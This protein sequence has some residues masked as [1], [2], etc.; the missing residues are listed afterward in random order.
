MFSD[1][2]VLLS[3]LLLYHPSSPYFPSTQL[4]SAVIFSSVIAVMPRGRTPVSL[5][6]RQKTKR[7]NNQKHNLLGDERMRKGRELQ[8]QA[9]NIST[10]P[11]VIVATTP[12][13][14]T[15]CQFPS[16]P[17]ETLTAIVESLIMRDRYGMPS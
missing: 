3:A 8:A 5:E 4:R 9:A 6:H 17:E 15:S 16:L 2:L 7:E 13:S 14:A 12:D 11:V 1:Q 10:G